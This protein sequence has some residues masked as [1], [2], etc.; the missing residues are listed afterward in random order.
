MLI[1]ISKLNPNPYRDFDLYP[2]DEEQIAKLMNSLKSD[3]QWQTV[4]AR[5]DPSNKG[6]YQLAAGHHRVEAMRRLGEMQADVT[7]ESHSDDGMLSIMIQENATQRG[8][9]SAAILDSVAAAMKR[10]AYIALSSATRPQLWTGM[11][12]N[13]RDADL[14][15]DECRKSLERG[16]GIGQ[17]LLSKFPGMQ[18]LSQGEIEVALATIKSSDLHIRIMQTVK[19]RVDAEVQQAIAHAEELRLKAE[20]MASAQRAAEEKAKK[21]ADEYRQRQVKL[22]QE[23]LEAKKRNDEVVAKKKAA[24]A[25]AARLA[26]E[27]RVR[28]LEELRKKQDET[29]KAIMEQSRM[30]A[31]GAAN[32]QERAKASVQATKKRT[33]EKPVLFDTRIAT[34]FKNDHQLE[35]F[36]KAVTSGTLA[37]VLPK[38]KQY[39]L[40]KACLDWH[41]QNEVRLTEKSIINWLNSELS[42]FL[43]YDRKI[44]K[45]E[46]RRAMRESADRRIAKGYEDI[47]VGLV[48]VGTGYAII[49]EEFGRYPEE[50]RFPVNATLQNKI[51]EAISQLSRLREIISKIN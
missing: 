14:A 1:E 32:I 38:E 23:R 6:F 48:K 50:E 20:R 33:E 44:S 36:R 19:D 5:K 30:E 47:L 15:F 21:D 29:A 27:E 22:E 10:I 3:G 24:A 18:S 42:K 51:S 39:D 34:L 12:D 17:R 7:L 28:A 49:K 4:P 13:S 35:L 16:V 11:F 8:Q 2:Y 41:E 9:N 40:A 37:T 43:Q 25:E 45:E 26:E 46:E 31:A